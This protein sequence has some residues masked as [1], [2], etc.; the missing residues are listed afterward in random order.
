[1]K[2]RRWYFSILVVLISLIVFAIYVWLISAGTWTN[3]PTLSRNYSKLASS[4]QRGELWLQTKPSPALLALP[5]PYDP[6]A[7]SKAKARFIFDSSLYNG[8]IYLYWGPT[9]AII[10][11]G[12]QALIPINIGDQFI[13][14]ISTY[15]LFIINILILLKLWRRFFYDLP[16]WA[17]LIAILLTGLTSPLLWMLSR[18]KMYEAAISSGQVFLMGGFYLVYAFLEKPASSIWKLTLGGICWTL[19]IAS[20][21]TLIVPVSFFTITTF[22]LA[23]KQTSKGGFPFLTRLLPALALPLLLGAIGLGWYNWARFDSPFETGLRYQL[24]AWDLSK[25]V[26][27]SFGYILPNL[28]NY[29]FNRF[30]LKHT[31]P[32]LFARAGENIRFL[33]IPALPISSEVIIGIVI[34]TPFIVFALVALIF[35][36]KGGLQRRRLATN[37]QEANQPPTYLLEWASISLIGSIVLTFFSL[38]AY[39]YETMRFLADFMPSLILLSVLGFWQGLQHLKIHPGKSQSLYS[40]S[41]ILLATLSCVFSFLPAI[42]D[43]ANLVA[44]YNPTLLKA[45]AS[46]FGS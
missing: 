44:K 4:F 45:I 38:L 9:P 7:R 42:A 18:P 29:L 30:Q 11:A 28:Y 26:L 25:K 46:F 2:I 3:W 27:F 34:S 20:R 32:F 5:N 35:L 10:L 23:I 33:S 19:A 36:I 8:K 13:V 41:A 6:A 43:P 1:M 31:F 16:A 15:G 37:D 40:S 24:T 17:F 22:L 12:I 21:L 39:F 14:F